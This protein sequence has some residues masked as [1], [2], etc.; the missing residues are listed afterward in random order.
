MDGLCDGFLGRIASL[1][2]SREHSSKDNLQLGVEDV[3]L[4]KNFVIREI[5]E[6][7]QGLQLQV[8]KVEKVI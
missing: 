4:A 2:K 5:D 6:T 1:L 3:A 7:F 8:L